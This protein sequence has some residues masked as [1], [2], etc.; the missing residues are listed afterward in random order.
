MEEDFRTI[1]LGN[2]A[3]VSLCSERI[4]WGSRLQGSIL[5]AVVMNVV[6]D[7]QQHTMLGPNGLFEGRVQVDCYGETFGSTK[8]ASRAVR[9]ALD[10]YRGLGFSGIFH[11]STRDSREGGTNEADRPYRTSLDFLTFWRG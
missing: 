3:V 8:I 6:A 10:G 4:Y 9:D 2:A 11:E 5:P 7:S 1:L